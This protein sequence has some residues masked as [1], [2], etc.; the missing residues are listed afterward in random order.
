MEW[1]LLEVR[2]AETELTNCSLCKL[3]LSDEW[4]FCPECGTAL[5]TSNLTPRDF[6]AG[7]AEAALRAQVIEIV[8]N[9]AKATKPSRIEI[10]KK[11]A[12]RCRDFAVKQILPSMEKTSCHAV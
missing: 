8:L 1:L 6:S 10:V 7:P 3:L 4:K 11:I 5:T 12:T 9:Q 2:R